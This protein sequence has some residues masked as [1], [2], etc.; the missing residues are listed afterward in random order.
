MKKKLPCMLIFLS[1]LIASCGLNNSAKDLP[2]V[3]VPLNKMNTEFI[4]ID[5]GTGNSYRN[6]EMLFLGI[7]NK[8]DHSIV[9]PQDYGIKIFVHRG[10][11]WEPVENI[12]QY[13]EGETQLS[14]AKKG[15][16]SFTTTGIVP[17]I[18]DMKNAET[19]RVVM[20]GHSEND[21]KNKVGA[22]V[23]IK[24]NP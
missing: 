2:G 4:L 9:L 8:S 13:P 1:L 17:Q 24:I 10:N 16:L 6:E 23:D 19:I 14:S 3:V 20:V 5:P 21:E 22:F 18:P 12:M 7:Q 11:G 15:P